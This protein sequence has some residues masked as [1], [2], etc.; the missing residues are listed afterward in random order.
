VVDKESGQILCTHLAKGAVHDFK[1]FKISKLRLNAGI[2][3]LADAGYQG[4]KKLIT[5]AQT[6]KKASKHHPLTKADKQAN[7]QHSAK[8]I[9]IENVIGFMKRFK[10]FATKYRNRRKRLGLRFNLFAAIA[11]LD[12]A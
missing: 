1:L 8:R 11:N 9:K 5:N 6:P 4:I 7:H 10:V 3:L 12:S 2:S